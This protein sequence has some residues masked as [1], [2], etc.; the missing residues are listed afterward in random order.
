MDWR[1]RVTVD[2]QILVGK[3]IIKGTRISVEQVLQALGDGWGEAGVLRAYPHL[4]P[5]DIH[6][7][8]AYAAQSLASERIYPLSA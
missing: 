8:L 1:T 6:A 5:E 4:T 3:P 7:C 2:P